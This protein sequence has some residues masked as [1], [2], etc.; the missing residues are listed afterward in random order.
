MTVIKI[1]VGH[2]EL[3]LPSYIYK[4]LFDNLVIV[5]VP[6]SNDSEIIMGEWGQYR[7][8]GMSVKELIEAIENNDPDFWDK[9]HKAGLPLAYF[10]NRAK[11]IAQK[12]REIDDYLRKILK[13]K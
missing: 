2:Q 8:V 10:S 3:A 11:E 1:K 7:M 4:S 13:C 6:N 9:V 5:S 12:D